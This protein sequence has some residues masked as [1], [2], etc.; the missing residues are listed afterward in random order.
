MRKKIL[1]V[2][3]IKE[4]RALLKVLLSGSYDVVTAEDGEKALDMI[5][6]GFN[7]DV[8]VTDLIMPG[9]DGYQLIS[10]IRNKKC[11]SKIPIIVLSNV[12]K[13]AERQKLTR[14][15]TIN[16]FL[17]KPFNTHELNAGLKKSLDSLLEN[18]N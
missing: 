9:M 4:F 17:H 5:E 8:I 12:D 2:D 13:P 3:D 18:V 16:T 10:N 14:S 6:G 7:P 1:L 15:K 11:W